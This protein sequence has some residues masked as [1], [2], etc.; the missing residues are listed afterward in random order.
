MLTAT[1]GAERRRGRVT[2][3]SDHERDAP[4]ARGARCEAEE[5]AR[6]LGDGAPANHPQDQV[7]LQA[8]GVLAG[9]LESAVL[10]ENVGRTR[11]EREDDVEIDSM[12][13]EYESE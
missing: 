9:P 6:A 5:R 3:T 4:R 7:A 2:R 10:E 11:G 12:V 8:L 13:R 1:R